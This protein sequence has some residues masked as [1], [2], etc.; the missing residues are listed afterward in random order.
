MAT[1]LAEHGANVVI[2]GRTEATCLQAAADVAAATGGNVAGVPTHAGDVEAMARL[3]DATIEQF[4]R[5][6]IVINNAGISLGMP[7]GEITLKGAQKS[8]DVNFLGPLFLTQAALPHLRKS[9]CPSVINVLTTGTD[10]PGKGLA[11]Y[12]TSKA[13]LQMLTRAMAL[14]LAAEGVR[15]NAISPG[16]FSTDM[17]NNMPAQRRAEVAA[18]IPLGRIAD[19]AEIVGSVLYLSTEA[20]SFMT[21]HVLVIDGGQTIGF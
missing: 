19:P 6:D 3:V 9:P 21:G 5:L 1:G 20:S 16:P 8:L 2:T 17:L 18:D 7:V 14:E 11:V 12:T 15:V 10:R 13:A 4:G